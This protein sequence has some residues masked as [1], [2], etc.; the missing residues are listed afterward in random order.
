MR[1]CSIVL[2][3]I[4]ASGL[5]FFLVASNCAENAAAELRPLEINPVPEGLKEMPFKDTNPEI[6]AF[7]HF[8][9][10]NILFLD[11]HVTW[12]KRIKIPAQELDSTAWKSSF[13]DPVAWTNDNW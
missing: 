4:M 13:W 8:N 5:L 6:Q 12:L 1:D 2:R 3:G 10:A 7:P 11:Y 9:G